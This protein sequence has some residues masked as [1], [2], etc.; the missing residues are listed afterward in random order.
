MEYFKKANKIFKN[1]EL[2]KT[3]NAKLISV[4]ENKAVA[5]LK[6]DKEHSNYLGGLHG[7][8]I[9]AIVDTVAFFPGKLLPS[10]LKLTTSGFNIEFFRAV[11]LGQIIIFEAK[12]LYFGKRK[13]NVEVNKL[14][15]EPKK[16]IST[17][18]VDLMLIN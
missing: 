9:S 7:G 3:I 14:L 1:I 18:N 5:E 12:I 11:E 13:V 4:S 2:I 10:G 17:S 16:L 6:V 8:V 15:K